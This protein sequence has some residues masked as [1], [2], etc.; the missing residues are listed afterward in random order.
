MSTRWHWLVVPALLFAACGGDDDGGS[1]EASGEDWCAL[2]QRIEDSDS[3]FD[4]LVGTD[5][6]AVEE[7]AVELQGL[8]DEAARVAPEEILAEVNTSADGVDALVNLLADVDYDITRVEEASIVRLDELSDEMDAATERIE[9]YNETECGIVADRDDESADEEPADAIAADPDSD[10]CAAARDVEAAGDPF[11][12]AGFDFTDPA[13]VEVA[14]GDILL[15]LENARAVAPPEIADAVE[16]SYN[17]FLQ[18]RDA[19]AEVDYDFLRADLAVI[20]EL[21]V[22][23]NT[24]VDEIGVYNEAVCGIPADGPSDDDVD[25]SDFDPSAGSIRDQTVAQLV[26]QGFTQQEAECIFD[27]I[28]LT[29][30]DLASDMNVIIE[31]FEICEIDLA[32]LAEL[33]G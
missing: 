17:G 25:D 21:D 7:A 10:W 13:S 27:Q 19:L 24:A 32:R 22:E 8:L 9:A 5:P 18:L 20:D 30:P 4:G 26:V 31:V 11:D 15:A 33:A 3:A 14:F 16:T 23:M 6:S 29:D 12:A 1:S 28:D 2:A